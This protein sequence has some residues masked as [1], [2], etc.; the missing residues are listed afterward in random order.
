MDVSRR[1]FV[2]LLGA[3]WAAASLNPALGWGSPPARA[4]QA[5]DPLLHLLNRIT[6]GVRPED[7]TWATVIGY[8]AYLEEQLHPE[9]L[10]DSAMDALLTELPILMMDRQT[11]TAL[12]NS[13][14]RAYL[15]ITRGLILRAVHS[16]HQLKERIVEFWADHFNMPDEELGPELVTYHRE[17]L[18]RHALGNFRDL[19]FKTAQSPA[20]LYYLDNYLNVAEHPNENYARELLELHTLGVDGGYTEQDVKEVAR[21][22]TGWTVNDATG[23]GFYF[24]P[25]VHDTAEKTVL[26]HTLPAE[27]GIED[28]LHVLSIVANH[29][30]TPRFL[31]YKLC[32]RFV[33]DNPPPA[34]V[35]SAAAVWVE[36]DGE[37]VPVLRHIFLSDEFRQFAWQKLRRPLEF[38]V[39]ALRATRTEI[40]DF[41]T[42][43]GF[44][45]ELGQVPYG[46]HPPD[47]YPDV[48]AAWTTSSG[49]LARWNTAF[50]LTF[51]AFSDPDAGMSVPLLDLIGQP[52]TAG[53]LVDVAAQRVFAA[54]LPDDQRALY[55]AFVSDDA[56]TDTPV[57]P[58]LI[59]RKVGMLFGL[60]L[61]SH[62]FQWR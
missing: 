29:P 60:M 56:G 4:Q 34:L 40:D 52:A 20:M 35:D 11:A 41:Y 57:T 30:A 38:F 49:L 54:P 44:V 12:P 51:S 61:A 18:R 24:D 26:G 32:V 6:W 19:L 43:E 48:A 14:Y 47:G 45:Q 8:E 59:A 15:S 39:A 37:I 28:G 27:R 36:N 2:K 55:V 17:V 33:S 22:F 16:Q 23:D 13:S 46:W 5:A 62:D 9:R 3:A 1:E 21:A 25:D 7:L 10:D 53:D 42:L 31:C 58:H 50:A